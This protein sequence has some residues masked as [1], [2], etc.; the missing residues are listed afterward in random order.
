GDL[1]ARIASTLLAALAFH[2]DGQ[3]LAWVAGRKV[4]L[5][6][7]LRKAEVWTV[8][9]DTGVTGL[10]FDAVAFCPAPSQVVVGSGATGR[11]VFHDLQTGREVRR[12]VLP[13]DR[14]A[15]PPPLVVAPAGR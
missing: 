7:R 8:E 14:S 5:W 1:Q 12:A 10:G 2:P 15:V 13:V 4:T 11:V 9:S 6:D 3:Y